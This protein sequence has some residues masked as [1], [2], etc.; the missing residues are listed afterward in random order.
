MQP[1]QFL[2]AGGV[3]VYPLLALSVLVLACAGERC[4][5]WGR[6]HRLQGRALA[7]LLSAYDK[8]P[9]WIRQQ[10]TRFVQVP[11]VRVWER[12]LTAAVSGS[13]L[14][15]PERFRVALLSAAQRELP[16]LRRFQTVL[17]TTVTV[18]PL[19]GLLGTV[20]G[21]IRAFSSLSLGNIGG[22]RALEV[23][24]GVSEALISTAMGLVIAIG[25]LAVASLFRSFYRRQLALLQE[26]M[27]HLELIYAEWYETQP[28][29]N[30]QHVSPR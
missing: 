10:A 5:F 2:A 25:T 1:S 30:G 29:E 15:P 8:G 12:A 27:G 16:R 22:T 6:L 13:K 26:V 24:G 14:L 19:L 17:D 9:D 7:E 23:T 11:W 18:A 4:W 3:V 28:W 21:L 20:T